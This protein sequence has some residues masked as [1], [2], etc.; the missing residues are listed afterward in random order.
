M[1]VSPKYRIPKKARLG[2][3]EN[4]DL[5]TVVPVGFFNIWPG[6]GCWSCGPQVVLSNAKFIMM[7]LVILTQSLTANLPGALAYFGDSNVVAND[8]RLT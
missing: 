3:R 1:A 2:K 5:K 6:P 4:E 7:V 8:R